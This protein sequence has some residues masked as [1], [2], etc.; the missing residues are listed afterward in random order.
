LFAKVQ[1]NLGVAKQTGEI[2]MDL[3]LSPLPINSDPALFELY[4]NWNNTKVDFPTHKCIAEIFRQQAINNPEAIAAVFRD[5]KITYKDLN[6][7]ANKLAWFLIE[8]GIGPDALVC[9]FAERSVKFLT[10]VIGI[11]KAGGAYLPLDPLSPSARLRNVLEQSKSKFIITTQA[12]FA[13]LTKSL[14]EMDEK[15]RPQILLI[16]ECLNQ[17]LSCEDPPIRS[18]PDDLVYV[19]FTSGST[20]LPKGAMVEQKGMMNHLYAKIKDLNLT[21]S[22]R[23]AQNASQC[24][25][26]SVWQFLAGLLVGGQIHIVDEDV[27]HDTEALLEYAESNRIS[28]LEV[29][30]SMLRAMLDLIKSSG[31]D[32]PQLSALRWMILTGEALPPRYCAEWLGLYPHIPMFN[33]YGP[34]ECSDDVTHYPIYEAPAEDVVHMPIGYPVANM[35]LYVVEQQAEEFKLCPVGASGELCVTGIG[36]GRGYINDA[37]RTKAAFFKDP[38]SENSDARLYRTGDLARYLPDGRIEFLGRIDSQVKIRGFRI[39]LGE[40]ESI[41]LRHEGVK[42]CAVIVRS[43]RQMQGKLVARECLANVEADR[44][45]RKRLLAYLVCREEISNLALRGFLQQYLP[46]YMIP[47]QFIRLDVLPLNAN[48]KVDKNNLPE[49]ENARPDLD[50][51]F[52]APRN[53][54]E[55]LIASMWQDQLSV[56]RIGVNDSFF[57]LGGDSLLAIQVLNRLRQATNANIAFRNFFEAGTVAGLARIIERSEKDASSAPLPISARAQSE[58]YRLSFAQQRMWFLWKLEPDN[59]YYTFQGILNVKGK[60]N[61]PMFRRAW[62]AIWKRH[63]ILRARFGVGDGSPFQ[64]FDDGEGFDPLFISLTHLPEAERHQAVRN[65]ARAEAERAFDL[66]EGKLF[67]I[68]LFKLSEAEHIALLTMHEIILDGWATCVMIRELGELYNGFIK[69]VESPLPDLTV[70]FSDFLLWEGDNFQRDALKE[71]ED[72]WREKL[73]GELPILDLATDRP[74]PMSPTFLGKSHGILL[75][76]D[77]SDQIHRLSRQEGATLFI[78]ILAAFYK[79]LRLYTGQD[80]LI[81]GA[82]LANRSHKDTEDIVGFFL[83]M[84]AFRTDISGDPSFIDLMRRVRETVTEGITRSDYPFIWLLETVNAVRNPSIAPVFQVMLNMLS[85]P[86]VT[87]QYNDLE[88]GFRE[89]ETGYTKYD[90]SLYAQEQGDQVYLQLSYPTDMFDDEA[91]GRILNNMVAVLNS[92]IANPAARMSHLEVLTDAEKKTILSD[93][94]FS[95]TAQDF[96][97]SKRIY[98]LFELQAEKTPERTALIFN[99]QWLCYGALNARSNQL[100]NYLR[101]RGVGPEMGVA[102]CLERSFDTIIALLGIIKAGGYYVAL[103]PDYPLLRLNK[104][105]QDTAAP[106][107]LLHK[108]TDQFEDYGGEKI[109][110][111]DWAQLEKE[112]ISNPSCLST[113]SNPLNIVYTSSTTGNPK[114]AFITMKS[115]LNRIF[116][117]WEAYPFR[118]D[119][120]AVLQ[121]S[122]AVV[123][124]T[125]ECFGALL[126]G[127]PTLILSREDLLDQQELWSQLVTERVSYLLASPALLQ[128][129]IDH[130]ASHPSEWTALR[131]TT[132]SA[133]PISVTMATQ[134][135]KLFP[136]APLLNLYGST[137]CSS[138]VTVYDTRGISPDAS[139]VLV[140]KPLANTRVYILGEQL[141]LV[142]MGGKGEMCVSGACLARGYL[143]LPELTAERFIPDPFSDRPGSRLYRTGDVARHCADGNIELL[144]RKDNQIKVRGFRVELDDIEAAILR[145]PLVKKCAVRVYQDQG[146]RN[147]LAAYLIVGDG[148]SASTIRRFLRER[149]PEYMIPSDFVMVDALPLTPAGKVDRRALP[150][151]DRTRPDLDSTFV[152]PHTETQS[153]IAKIW[154]QILGVEHVGVYDDFFDLGGH[155][156]MATQILS[157]LRD[158]VNVEIPLRAMYEIPTVANLAE[159]VEAATRNL[160]LHR[161]HTAIIDKA[162]YWEEGEL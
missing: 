75:D 34:T 63:E 83:N 102:V 36:V 2:T 90:L 110:L 31:N 70:K 111:D 80:D 46:P 151:P 11:F 24:F 57:D 138:N 8:R 137:E 17:A 38:F 139:R 85:F 117:M 47:E 123:A 118:P 112:D 128:G 26:I 71:Q 148:M 149:L 22:D 93:F 59:P 3:G 92:A 51:P 126:K 129:V 55:A 159:A 122:T 82:P 64:V 60:L 99:G 86:Q 135:N 5:Q 28:I 119:D 147:R 42:E 39:E 61:F 150:L 154:S 105:L 1:S 145:H 21:A 30:P 53:E 121:K 35:R 144:G 13:A 130:A 133:E 37:Q 142:P 113:P 20:G 44:S 56:D 69:G 76:A 131:L 101:W 54:L 68:Q 66:E 141:G 27:A 162:V 62:Q 124:A 72:Y 98:E 114:G 49:P 87:L 116:W 52:V 23:I 160:F 132:T 16:E 120:V 45:E 40:I 15:A 95:N 73:A 12:E 109:Y 14:D 89:L 25:D 100:A 84:L 58:R 88:M 94:N 155:S 96:D 19:I 107:L 7:S 146:E 127:I 32:S 77:L 125:W 103:D 65:R 78:V 74:R 161:D 108:N 48:G 50:Q 18:A 157:R 41:L 91:A 104:M 6:K 97:Y 106:I 153:L 134:W 158:I 79:T 152:A 136:Q 29:V 143:N 10:S 43:A 9:I 4:R 33:A 67:R 115:A 81:I 140:G 156:L